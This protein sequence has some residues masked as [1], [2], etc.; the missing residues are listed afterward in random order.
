MI[1]D[2]ICIEYTMTQAFQNQL[3]IGQHKGLY[4]QSLHIPSMLLQLRLLNLTIPYNYSFSFLIATTKRS[5]SL[6]ANLAERPWT[7]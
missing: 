4:I 3:P 6:S 7:A 2:S 5:V 1:L